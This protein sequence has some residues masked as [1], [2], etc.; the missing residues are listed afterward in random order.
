[1][2]K[3]AT[4]PLHDVKKIDW[5]KTSFKTKKHEYTILRDIPL[6]RFIEMQ[7]RQSEFAFG[8]SWDGVIQIFN[9]I[10][11]AINGGDLAKAGYI[12]IEAENNIVKAQ[13]GQ[14]RYDATMMISTIFLLREDEDVKEFSTEMSNEKIQDWLEEGFS[15]TDFFSLVASILPHFFATFERISRSISEAALRQPIQLINDLMDMEAAKRN[16]TTQ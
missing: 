10:K 15:Y 1:M 2:T 13:E 8:L 11:E 5:S 6:S 9:D 3:T 16:D 12:T 7:K 14:I 4:N